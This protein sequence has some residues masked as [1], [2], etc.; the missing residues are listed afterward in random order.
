M[1]IEE[2]IAEIKERCEAASKGPWLTLH[3]WPET[4][5]MKGQE[6][7]PIGG[8]V[9]E[10]DD[11][12]RFAQPIVTAEHDRYFKWP[13]RPQRKRAYANAIFISHARQDIPWL[14]EQVEE[15]EA[16]IKQ[17]N[18][19]AIRL[20][21]KGCEKHRG[22]TL[23][24]VEENNHCPL[25]FKELKAHNGMLR[26]ALE[27]AKDL[28]ERDFK[29][30]PRCD[31]DVGIC[32]CQDRIDYRQLLKLLATT[33]QDALKKENNMAENFDCPHCG[34]DLRGPSSTVELE[35]YIKKL[36]AVVE[37]G[38]AFL[39]KVVEVYNSG[40]MKGILVLAFAHRVEYQGP[41]FER[42]EKEFKDALANLKED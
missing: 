26:E 14:I 25:C 42:E 31:H 22:I 5:V 4:I 32:G 21:T 3:H 41:T 39:G 2:R 18:D 38:Q 23:A 6:N 1:K 20:L 30:A 16:Q 15:V 11:K 24:E 8:S 35:G 10:E 12:K 19:N 27:K 40:E 33:P 29:S 9:N 36:E 7:L 13:H 28:Y 34:Q 17:V 37:K